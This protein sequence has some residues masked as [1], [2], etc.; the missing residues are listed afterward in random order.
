MA[1]FA[2]IA[3]AVKAVIDGLGLAGRTIVRK[4][5]AIQ[6]RDFDAYGLPLTLVFLKQ[7]A[8]ESWG[9]TGDGGLTGYGTVGRDVVVGIDRFREVQGDISSDPADMPDDFQAIKRALNKPRLAG[10]ATVWLVRLGTNP[11]W[12]NHAFTVGG[13][14]SH[15]D[16]TV[17][18]AEPRN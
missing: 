4:D 16:L 6:P 7:D 13:E 2:D 17:H 9:T 1:T 18:G 5:G 14:Q 8:G 12:E 3:A 15:C 11:L 10:A